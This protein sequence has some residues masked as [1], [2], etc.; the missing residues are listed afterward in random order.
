MSWRSLHFLHIFFLSTIPRN[1]K[2]FQIVRSMGI[3]LDICW[4]YSSPSALNTH[5]N[6]D[7][8]CVLHILFA[9]FIETR[10]ST[11]QTE[12]QTRSKWLSNEAISLL[13]FYEFYDFIVG[14]LSDVVLGRNTDFIL[15]AT[16]TQTAKFYSFQLPTIMTHFIAVS[17]P[18]MGCCFP[19][20]F[21]LSPSRTHTRIQ[22]NKRNNFSV[23][24]EDSSQ[25]FN[26]IYRQNCPQNFNMTHTILVVCY[27][28]CCVFPWFLVVRCCYQWNVSK[29]TCLLF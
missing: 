21:L 22:Q 19:F 23:W 1:T 12:L 2:A 7:F 4:N 25:E 8:S 18:N 9:Q 14:F 24:S 13:W 15:H 6:W 29:F 20:S 11:H 26:D 3:L 17:V 5:E 28:L 16:H 10:Q 27:A